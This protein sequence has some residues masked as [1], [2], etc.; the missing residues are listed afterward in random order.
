MV[1]ELDSQ[2]L[3]DIAKTRCRLRVRSR[4]EVTFKQGEAV[5]WARP[6]LISCFRGPGWC[7][8]SLGLHVLFPSPNILPA[9]QRSANGK[10][11][12][13]GPQVICSS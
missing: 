3:A 2:W 9:E 10:V 11:G 13:A 5:V 4:R 1:H 8:F 7:L 12:C 6:G